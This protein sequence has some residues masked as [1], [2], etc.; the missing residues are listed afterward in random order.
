MN[1]IDLNNLSVQDLEELVAQKR[2]EEN[3]AKLAKRDAYEGIRAQVVHSVM[4]KVE[5]VTNDVENLHSFVVDE[6]T[7]F[8]D[9]M[10]EYGQLRRA[11]QMSYT[12]TEGNYRIE[13]RSNKV[14]RFD[15]RADVAAARLIE[16]MRKWIV[17]APGGTDNPMYQLAM[18]L[19]ERNKDGDLD[20]K[21]ISKL[22]ELES[23]FNEQ[24]Y[25]EIME[26]F[27]ESHL[28][29]GNATRYYFFKRDEHGVWRKI[30]PSFNRMY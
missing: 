29:E 18:V 11:E 14:K 19:L 9:V 1:G 2:K 12:I 21:N 17:N 20:Y 6:T 25:S 13:V 27:K 10:S 24:E 23:K 5:Q 7:G 28:V 26:L 16:F 8:K 22:Y 3:D 15:E 4:S 30:E